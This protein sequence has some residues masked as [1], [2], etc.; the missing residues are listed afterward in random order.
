[1]D[2]W[3]VKYWHLG[4]YFGFILD[5]GKTLFQLVSLLGFVKGIIPQIPHENNVRLRAIQFV[6]SHPSA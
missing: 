3:C 4:T 5:V 1:M 2:F 6:V